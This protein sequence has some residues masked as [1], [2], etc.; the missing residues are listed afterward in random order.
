MPQALMNTK[1]V[2][3]YLR[4]KERKIYDLVAHR[5]IPCAR[6]S[7]K[8]LFPKDLIDLWLRRNIE[9]SAARKLYPDPPPI[10][11]GSH[12]PSL[13][14]AVR[15]SG[16]DLALLFGGSLDGLERFAEGQAVACGL[17]VLD[18]EQEQYNAPLIEQR[19]GAEPVVLIEWARRQQG[20]IVAPGNPLGIASLADGVGKRLAIRQKESGTYLL[21]DYLLKKNHL[22]LADFIVGTIPLRNETEVAMAVA[23]G[24]AD[25]GLG[26][27]GAA[28][29]LPV[30]FISVTEERYD[31]LMWR[32]SYFEPTLQA[33]F[34]FVRTPSFTDYA[35]AALGYRFDELGRVHFNGP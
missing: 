17:H 18:S 30:D 6:I 20:L 28:R 7:G 34:S 4:L 3:E 23:S 8:W 10:V 24:Q 5:Q 27:F 15:E 32:R 31:L 2:A 13:E 33:L 9:G 21:L 29:Q 19:F 1:E 25:L 12:D 26:I 22:T 16:S 14:W 11:A 35:S